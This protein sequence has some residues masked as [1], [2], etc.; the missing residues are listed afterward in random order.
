[1]YV[2]VFTEQVKMI[3]MFVVGGDICHCLWNKWRCA[4]MFVEW[5]EMRQSVRKRMYSDSTYGVGECLYICC[6][7]V[8]TT[9][10]I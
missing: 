4:T 8:M 5:V 6:F 3:H 1:M 2:T 10:V 9:G 7:D